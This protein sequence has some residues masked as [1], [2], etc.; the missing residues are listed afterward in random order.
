MDSHP[1]LFHLTRLLQH[2]S[3]SL[4]TLRLDRSPGLFND[5]ENTRLLIT[6]LEELHLNFCHLPGHAIIAFFQAFANSNNSKRHDLSLYYH[7]RLEGR[8]LEHGL[9]IIPQM[10]NPRS[11]RVN[12]DFDNAAVLSSCHH[13]MKIRASKICTTGMVRQLQ[14]PSLSA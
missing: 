9:N 8:E 11:L 1:M 6:T 4:Q 14:A 5:A 3:S 12:L 2:E 10:R 13:F 7:A